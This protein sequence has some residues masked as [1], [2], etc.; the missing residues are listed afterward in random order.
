LKSLL[1]CK[2]GESDLPFIWVIKKDNNDVEYE[3]IENGKN[4]Y[5][6]DTNKHNFVERVIR[7]ITYESI[8]DK[9][10]PFI[11]GIRSLIPID[12]ISIFSS[13]EFDFLLSGQSQIDITD[14]KQ[15]TIYKGFYNEEHPAIKNFWDILSDLESDKLLNF[16]KFCTGCTRVPIDGFAAL[17]GTRN[18]FQKFCIESSNFENN[19]KA[20]LI[21]AKTCFNR[22]YLPDYGSKEVMR[23]YIN[24]VIDNDTNYFGIQ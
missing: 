20:R 15:N 12:I 8:K 24:I 13:E 14:W 6:N 22:I 9:I 5:I 3:L 23:K 4:I 17:Q 10:S 7:L 18:K 1:S 2:L 16:F 19:N 21:E 11:K